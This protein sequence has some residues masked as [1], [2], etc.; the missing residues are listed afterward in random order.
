MA[1]AVLAAI[2][3]WIDGDGPAFARAMIECQ[4]AYDAAPDEAMRPDR[5]YANFLAELL[6]HRLSHPEIYRIPEGAPD[7]F[8]LGDS[9]ALC[10]ANTMVVL[11][12]SRRVRAGLF[13]G[14]KGWHIG[15]GVALG[16]RFLSALSSTPNAP[17]A[18]SFG[19]ID[20]RHD[21]GILPYWRR[22]GGDLESIVGEQVERAVAATIKAANG[23][24]IHFLTVP[25]VNPRAFLLCGEQEIPDVMRV[26]ALY[27]EALYKY[28]P[29]TIDIHAAS[30]GYGGCVKPEFALD[31]AHLIPAMLARALA[32]L[33]VPNSNDASLPGQSGIP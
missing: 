1:R 5:V 31:F 12:R 17:I 20:C 3:Y 24:Q 6:R 4:A 22:A 2:P 18:V 25:P 26:I 30:V 10:Y 7:L 27:N 8:L 19:E 15:R 33:P 14:L 21:E 23:K 13:M 9:H 11:D 32:D 29:K 16:P 28:A